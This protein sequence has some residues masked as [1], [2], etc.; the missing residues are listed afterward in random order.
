MRPKSA[1]QFRVG[2]GLAMKQLL[3]ATILI[4]AA[5]LSAQTLAKPALPDWMAGTWMMEDGANWSDELWTDPRGGIMFGIS[6]TGFGTQ[7][8]RW[9]LSQ[10]RF[11]PDGRVSLFVILS[12]KDVMPLPDEARRAGEADGACFDSIDWVSTITEGSIYLR[13]LTVPANLQHMMRPGDRPLLWVLAKEAKATRRS[14]ERLLNDA[15]NRRPRTDSEIEEMVRV[16]NGG[17]IPG[18]RKAWESVRSNG[19]GLKQMDVF[20]V[21]EAIVKR[22]NLDRTGGRPPKQKPS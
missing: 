4:L 14:A 2:T 21:V 15:E 13:G 22:E 18:K 7:L 20:R 16:A 11:K 8:E 19:S 3:A 5:P 6:R 9:D 1:V 10:I 17:S 12:D